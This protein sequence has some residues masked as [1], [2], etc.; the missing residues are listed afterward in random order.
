MFSHF[1][2]AA[3]PVTFARRPEMLLPRNARGAALRVALSGLAL[4]HGRREGVDIRR[5]HA[6]AHAAAQ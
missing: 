6:G 5:R 4:P 1:A 2:C 3:N